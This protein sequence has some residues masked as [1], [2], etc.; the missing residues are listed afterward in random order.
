M[1]YTEFTL[2]I[3]IEI[4][5]Q[6]ADPDPDQTAPKWAVNQSLYFLP[7]HQHPLCFSMLG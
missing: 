4:A 1:S 7:F 3:Q 6:N 2:T 5:F